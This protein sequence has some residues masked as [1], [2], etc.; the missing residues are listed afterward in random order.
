LG[1]LSRGA[2]GSSVAD[3]GAGQQCEGF[4]VCADTVVAASQPPEPGEPFQR[5]FDDIAVPAQPGDDAAPA[6]RAAAAAVVVALVGVQL[7]RAPAPC[8]RADRVAD[9]PTPAA[10]ARLGRSLP[11]LRWRGDPAVVMTVRVADPGRIVATG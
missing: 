10:V 9:P 4:E 8:E 2:D 6:Q 1:L 7:R 5:A 11:D 3:H